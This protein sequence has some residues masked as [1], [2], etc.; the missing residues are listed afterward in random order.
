MCFSGG[1]L[2]LKRKFRIIILINLM[3]I[4]LL[5][6]CSG[7]S[8][9]GVLGINNERAYAKA[10]M[11]EVLDSIENN[12]NESLKKLFSKKAITQLNDIDQSIY[13]LFDYFQGDFVSYDDWAGSG[14]ETTWDNG[15]KQEIIYSSFDV[16]TSTNEYRFAFKI[17]TV[18]TADKDN[19]GIHSLYIIKM[20][21]DI[22]PE[23][24]YVG[25]NKYT[26]G[27]HI[28]VKNTLPTEDDT[29]EAVS[30]EK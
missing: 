30:I 14:G 13:S 27:I 16:K 3:C 26:A 18:D 7:S 24:G 11:N 20:E 29:L 17:V 6:S 22:D 23:L 8:T 1:V 12:D 9:S 4:L 28:G 21:D 19:V 5:S 25:D 15:Y 10:K 2:S